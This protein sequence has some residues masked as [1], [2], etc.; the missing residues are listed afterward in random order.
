LV[1]D[2]TLSCKELILRSA[3]APAPA[4]VAVDPPRATI[5]QRLLRS[6]VVDLLLGPHGVDRYLELIHP[7]LT[8]TDAR[9]EVIAARRQTP[10][11]VTLTLRPN[12]AFGGVRAGQFVRVGIE[13][14]GVRRTRTY[15]PAGSEH[16]R[17]RELELTVTEHPGGLVSPYLIRNAQPGML[18]HLGQAQGEFTLPQ[19]RPRRL[20]LI[21]GGS[22]ITPV[23]AMLRT[24]VDEEAAGDVT[25]LHFARTQADWLYE[26]EARAMG[27]PTVG[28]H[29]TRGARPG[30]AAGRISAEALGPVDD[31][32]WAAV[33]GPPGLLDAARAIWSE[34]GGRPEQLLAETFT[35]PTLTVTGE[36]AEG[37]LR[38][39]ASDARASIAGGTLLEQA[40]AAGLAPA[41]GCRMGICRTCTCRKTAGTVRNL[42][43]G[44]LSAEADE[45][46]QLCVSVPAGDVALQL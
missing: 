18:L 44:E 6:P 33:C 30:R 41:F 35:A 15:S 23:L 7:R 36:A 43:T 19:A 3:S 4:P 16:G 1:N 12:R 26:D 9:A 14:D 31:D 29:A 5:T 20:V 32:T 13:I 46:I 34:R 45:D 8:V 2:R 25:F 27:G 38:F 42:I 39:L 40:E 10:R 11:S 28:Y 22:G 21:S 37:T 17:R 24:L